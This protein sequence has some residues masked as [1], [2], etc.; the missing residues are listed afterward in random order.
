V[1]VSVSAT[2]RIVRIRREYNTWVATETLEDYALRFA[3]RSFRKLSE[4][5]V[6]ETAFG[7]VSFLALEAI[8]G[9]LMVEHGFTNA[10]WAIL[11]V[12]LIIF[13]TGLPICYYAAKHNIDMDLLARGAGFGYIG[14]TITSLIYAS[15]TFIFFALEAAIMALVFELYFG[16]PLAL[17]YL[18]SSVLIIP[19]VMHGITLISRLQRWTTLPWL[20]MMIVPFI[21]ILAKKPDLAHE[22]RSFAGYTA[23]STEF[24]LLS[25]GMAATVSFSLIGQI[26]EQVDFLRFLPEKTPQNR[27]EWWAALLIAGPGWI[28]PGVLKQLAGA[29]LAFLCLQHLVPVERAEQPTQMYLTAWGYVFDDPRWAL[30]A[31]TIFVILSQ[32]KINVMNA[33]AGSLAWS[34]FFSRL[35]HSHPGRVVWL[36]FNVAIALLLMELG[37]FGALEQVLGLYSCVAIAWVGALVADLTINKPLKLSPPFIEFKRAYLYNVNPVGVGATLV[38]SVLSIVAYTGAFGELMH[39]FAPF[40]ALVTAMVLAPAIAWATGGRYYIARARPRPEELSSHCC[41]C[42]TKFEQEDMALCP[43][44]AGTICSLCCTLDARCHD[45]C[46]RAS[47]RPGAAARSVLERWLP[48]L[49]GISPNALARLQRFA[50]Y[51]AFVFGGVSALI[52]LVYHQQLVSLRLAPVDPADLLLNTVS[53][54]WA[55]SLVVCGVAAWWLVLTR[56]SRAVAEEESNRQTMLLQQE[57]EEHRKTDAA[58]QKA[59]EAAENANRAKS[60]FIASM[61]HELRTPLNSII[62]YAQIL[63]KDP[64]IPAHRRDA[65]DTIR[66][67]GEHLLALIEETLDV[68]RIEASQFKLRPTPTNFAE[69]LTQIVN[70]FRVAADRKGIYFRV[71][72]PDRLPR[73]VRMDQQ[74]VR[75]ILINLIGNAVKFTA[76]GGVELKIHYSGDIARFHVIDTGPGIAP[77]DIERIFQPF[78]RAQSTRNADDSTGLGLTISRMITERMGGELKVESE[79]GKGSTF[80]LRLFLPELRGTRIDSTLEEV[81]GYRGARRRLLLLDDQPEQRA[82]IRSMLQPLGFVIE[83]ASSGEECLEKLAEGAPDALLLDLFMPGMNGFEVCR[84]AREELCWDGPIIAVSANVFDADRERALACGCN[85]FVTKPVHLR[86]LLEQL[87]IQLALEWIGHKAPPAGEREP[88]WPAVPPTDR[89]LALR[90]HA[91]LGYVKGVNEEIERIGAADPI[92][93]DFTERVRELIKQFRTAEIVALVEESIHRE[94]AHQQSDRPQSCNTEA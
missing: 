94:R 14:S 8:G 12:G 29:F 89:L 30:A 38:A 34:N 73:V 66:Q 84:Q 20:V 26:G 67:S 36:V 77:A 78:Q 57:I 76:K 18:L 81:T 24:S 19:L 15:F 90:E 7:A 80:I 28:V 91:R 48:W 79:L 51:F 45:M 47:A 93:R 42:G 4:R 56:E 31:T 22:W 49:K 75:Q 25:F 85:A 83:E 61:S 21:F 65:T 74:R 58:L 87:Q 71:G 53:M 33:Y 72:L 6:G 2:Q 92:Y 37:V 41:I 70:M 40:V 1:D 9:T 10:L 54:I 68:A 13:A 64:T 86:T 69:F 46:K 44:Y 62:G 52:W 63:Q 50:L 82:V 55:A 88:E 5:H 60:R 27:R 23:G 16:I 3:P 59:K 43:A 39:A 17:G 35:T 32:T 11:A